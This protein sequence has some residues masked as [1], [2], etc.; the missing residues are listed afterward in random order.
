MSRKNIKN[1]VILMLIKNTNMSI[2]TQTNTNI[3]QTMSMR[4]QKNTNTSTKIVTITRT[5][6]NTT[7]IMKILVK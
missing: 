2:I 6:I 7:M 3:P 1:A 4:I 5:P